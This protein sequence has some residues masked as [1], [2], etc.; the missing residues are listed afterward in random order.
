MSSQ[1]K[2]S[3]YNVF[4]SEKDRYYVANTLTGSI[5]Q[6]N[7]SEYNAL[8]LDCCYALE[9]AVLFEMEKQ[10][11]VIDKLVDEIS[12]LRYAY[13]QSKFSKEKARVTICPTLECNF[14]CPSCYEKRQACVMS[15]EVQIGVIYY[16]KELISSGIRLISIVWYGGEPLL[17]PEIIE[18][19]SLKIMELCKENNVAYTCSMITNGF[20]ID[21]HILKISEKIKL[22]SIQITVDGDEKTHDSRRKLS[23]GGPTY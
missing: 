10:G 5:L 16:I 6:L 22:T 8:R 2:S 23:N 14:I 7:T 11:I 12:L 15:I 21:E 19:L 18:N 20:L 9:D 3:R 13:V 17:Y 1:W 4:F